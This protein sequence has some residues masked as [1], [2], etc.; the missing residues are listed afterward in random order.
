MIGGLNYKIPYLA[1]KNTA[2][3][4]D[5]ILGLYNKI[6]LNVAN[7]NAWGCKVNGLTQGMNSA[8][9]I[10]WAFIN[11]GVTYD[12]NYI[13]V[14]TKSNFDKIKPGDIV[15]TACKDSCGNNKYS[16]SGLVIGIESNKIFVA[17][18]SSNG[19]TMTELNKSKLPKDG[20]F[21]LVSLYDYANEG[22]L[23]D[24]WK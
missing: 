5:Q 8:S 7:S 24:M 14:D 19:I 17:H 21:A 15:L 1:L 23:T 12:D 18:F 9:F 16:N 3:D 20:T 2:I 4:P 6:G 13:T 11:A 22:N 10:K